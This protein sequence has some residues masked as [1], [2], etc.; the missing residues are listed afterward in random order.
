MTEALVVFIGGIGG[1]FI[2]MGL[3]YLSIR[4][5]SLAVGRWGGEAKGKP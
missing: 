1:V 4:I 5:T 3:L 2:G